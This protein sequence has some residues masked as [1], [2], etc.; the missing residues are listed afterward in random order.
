MSRPVPAAAPRARIH[1]AVFLALVATILVVGR[2]AYT[3][4]QRQFDVELRGEIDQ[5]A[6]QK[7]KQVDSR[8]SAAMDDVLN[9]ALRPA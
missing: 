4:Q 9:R 7:A 8:P 2:T 5:V 6:D 1:L 3:T